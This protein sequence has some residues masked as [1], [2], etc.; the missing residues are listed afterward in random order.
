VDEQGTT[1]ISVFTGQAEVA[2]LDGATIALTANQGV[3]VDALGQAGPRLELPQP[4]LPTAPPRQAVI[5]WS[6]SRGGVATLTWSPVEH[7]TSYRVAM[8]LN[9]EQAELLLSA[10]LDR[11]GIETAEHPMSALE[12]GD[13]YWRVA[14]VNAEGMAGAFSGV[15]S[16]SVAD[17]PP[18]PPPAPLSISDVTGLGEIVYVAGRAAPGS[19]VSAD[20]HILVVAPDGRFSEYLRRP[21]S[22]T[23]LIQ[24]TLPDGSL[25]E[26]R[27]SIV[28]TPPS[29]D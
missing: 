3:R 14:G 12:R 23:L 19:E 2:T 15:W 1:G 13:Y 20:G 22:D 27:R 25:S 29:G 28:E 9:V 26:E 7:G 6:E 17:P 4:P 18:A 16:F 5:P 10:A 8:D 11:E 24:A 21:A